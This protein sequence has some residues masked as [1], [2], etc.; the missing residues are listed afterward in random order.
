MKCYKCRDRPARHGGLCEICR[1]A[2]IGIPPWESTEPP[3]FETYKS[4]ELDPVPPVMAIAK[5]DEE[6]L[7][8]DLYERTGRIVPTLRYPYRPEY[9][10]LEE[11]FTNRFLGLL[12]ER[13]AALGSLATSSPWY[14]KDDI[15]TR[16]LS[17]RKSITGIGQ[18]L[19]HST[20]PTGAYPGRA[21]DA[22]MALFIREVI[23][24]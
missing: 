19:T 13:M 15:R 11:W 4:K 9:T 14:P 24:E 7:V 6:L 1:R 16:F 5:A 8:Y 20:N 2:S 21:P 10:R 3:S 18:S 12:E 23:R 22:L 17:F